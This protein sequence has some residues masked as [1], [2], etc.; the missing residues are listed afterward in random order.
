MFLIL[1]KSNL[2]SNLLGILSNAIPLQLLHFVISLFWGGI[3]IIR[4]SFQS[5][6]N[7]SS[8][9]ISVN[10]EGVADLL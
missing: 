8:F 4:P 6:G 9:H 3:L 1:F 7:F 2:E 5:V 10:R